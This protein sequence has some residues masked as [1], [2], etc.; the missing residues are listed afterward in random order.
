MPPGHS[1]AVE[2]YDD[3]SCNKGS[4]YLGDCSL[5]FSEFDSP[6]GFELLASLGHPLV[7]SALFGFTLIISR[8]TFM[9]PNYLP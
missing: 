8:K 3:L 5:K 4:I 2:Q 7:L 1:V 9:G 6:E